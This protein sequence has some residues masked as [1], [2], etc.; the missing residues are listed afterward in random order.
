MI[1]A[2][3]IWEQDMEENINEKRI[4]ILDKQINAA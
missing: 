1:K 2:T 4:I 3:L